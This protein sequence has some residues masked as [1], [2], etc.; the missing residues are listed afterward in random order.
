VQALRKESGRNR[1]SGVGVRGEYDRPEAHRRV[2]ALVANAGDGELTFPA[3]PLHAKSAVLWPLRKSS[4]DS[5]ELR[6]HVL[7]A[8]EQLMI[9][10]VTFIF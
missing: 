4:A 10:L 5:P 9:N 2:Y 3:S 1:H 6:I 8:K 7:Q